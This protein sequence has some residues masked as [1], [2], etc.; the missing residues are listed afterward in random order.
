[1]K[2]P[3]F[4]VDTRVPSGACKLFAEYIHFGTKCQ[5]AQKRL[6]IDVIYYKIRYMAMLNEL[7][8]DRF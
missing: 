8:S 3:S 7:N 6:T 2:T 4:V 5:S 1:M